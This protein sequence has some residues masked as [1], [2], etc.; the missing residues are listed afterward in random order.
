MVAGNRDTNTTVNDRT[1]VADR[2]E[3][4]SGFALWLRV[5]EDAF[6]DEAV[7]D[8]W[9][10]DDGCFSDAKFNKSLAKQTDTFRK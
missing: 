9:H 6:V 1:L 5:D 7:T 8:L 3:R 4:K 10:C 2:S